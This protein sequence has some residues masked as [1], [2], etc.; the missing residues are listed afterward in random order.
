M[1]N[2]CNV[3]AQIPGDAK[4]FTVLDSKMAFFF[5]AHQFIPHLSICLP[6]GGLTLTQAK[7][8]S[9]HGQYCLGGFGTTHT[10]WPGPGKTHLNKGI[11]PQHLDDVL[12]WRPS[13]EASDQIASKSLISLG[14]GV[15]VSQKK[16][17]GNK[18][19]IWDVL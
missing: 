4:Q 19:N 5:L 8:N 14:P 15:R 1:A 3:S 18:L 9:T 16:A 13:M 12:T 11:I 6:S 10:C 7:C 2:P 17:R